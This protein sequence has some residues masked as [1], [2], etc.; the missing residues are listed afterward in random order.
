M[1]RPKLAVIVANG[2]TG[3]SRVQKTALAAA[4]EGW[5]VTLIGRST[6]KDREYAWFGPVKVI[7]VPVGRITP[8][9]AA[10]AQQ[11]SVRAKVTQWGVA[12][13]KAL[14]QLRAVHKAWVR[15]QSARIGWK[16]DSPAA[17]V[18]VAGRKAWIRARRSAHNVRVRAYRW[19]EAHKAR[20]KARGVE[21]TGDWRHDWPG[22]VDLDLAFGPVI[23]ELEPDVIHANDITM[24]NTGALAAARLR[25]RG[26]S[27]P[28][29]TTPTSTSR[30]S[31][32]GCRSWT[33]PSRCGA[34]VHR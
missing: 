18:P 16:S 1:K 28:G 15:E 2:I 31:S 14:A 30:V 26:L 32:G 27:V 11:G 34:R 29:S 17:G 5:D 7:R 8:G 24:I 13:N 19:E 23:E 12:D 4:R 3:D 25:A 20:N 22:L 6:G 21:A 9:V 10:K 33:R